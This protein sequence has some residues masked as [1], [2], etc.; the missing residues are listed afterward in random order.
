MITPE[1]KH[2]QDINRQYLKKSGLFKSNSWAA[3]LRL[4]KDI[5]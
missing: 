2:R 4:S 1:N 5:S 3:K